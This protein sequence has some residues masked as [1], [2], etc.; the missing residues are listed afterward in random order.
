M[1][2]DMSVNLDV[3]LELFV[4][5]SST[6]S[7][8]P[9][10]FIHR[11]IC[12]QVDLC[13]VKVMIVMYANGACSV[14]ISSLCSGTRTFHPYTWNTLIVTSICIGQSV[15]QRTVLLYMMNIWW[16]SVIQESKT[17]DHIVPQEVHASTGMMHLTVICSCMKLCIYTV[18]S[19]LLYLLSLWKRLISSRMY[20]HYTVLYPAFVLMMI[21][22]RP[23]RHSY[24]S[25]ARVTDVALMCSYQCWHMDIWC[26]VSVC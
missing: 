19:G 13:S 20:H 12:L 17:F 11:L 9:N 6:Q 21:H 1:T 8:H 24:H 22:S 26:L 7:T 16:D 18:V 14:S 4:H 25:L 5:D 3:L 15:R 10:V 23:A 2:L